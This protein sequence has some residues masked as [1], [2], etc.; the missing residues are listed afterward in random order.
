V[1]DHIVSKETGSIH[2]RELIQYPPQPQILIQRNGLMAQYDIFNGDADGICSLIQLRLAEPRQAVLVTGIKRDIQLL[3]KVPAR[4]GDVLTV[5]DISMEKNSKALCQ[6]LDAGAQVFYADHHRTGEIPQSSL[7]D[8]HINVSANTCTGLIVDSVLKGQ[9]RRWAIVAAFGD[10][11]T[12]VA[13]ECARSLGLT[14]AQSN[15]LRDLGI[16]MNYN[17]YGADI[18]DLFYHP[19]ELFEAASKFEDPLQFI[20]ERKDIFETLTEGYREDLAKGLSADVLRSS[21]SAVM[22]R[23]PDEKW[24]RRISGVLGNELANRFPDR[25]HAI[26][27][28]RQYNETDGFLV[29]IRASKTHPTGADE[30]AVRFG[31][32]GRRRAAGIDFLPVE[33]LDEFAELFL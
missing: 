31:G 2:R 32:G 11:I 4:S 6:A 30:L 28:D 18:E 5:L 8:A 16:A 12:A 10:N 15:L 17:G 19:A 13:E 21:D 9:F 3:S 14:D 7:L 26:C 25:R 20:E 1:N 23:L 22:L 27:T 29:S 24:A 33:S